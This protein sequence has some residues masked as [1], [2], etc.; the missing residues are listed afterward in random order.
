MRVVLGRLVE[1]V[2]TICQVVLGGRSLGGKR[3][4]DTLGM[5]HLQRTIY[6]VGRDMVE[7]L[8]LVA[9]RQRFPVE[10][11]GLEHRE[12]THDVGLG[13]G[14]R[15]LNRA[16][17]VAL[18]SQVDDAGD[19]L[20][21]HQLVDRLEVADISPHEAIVRTVLDVLEVSQVARIGQL[22]HVDDAVVRI[23]VYKQAHNMAPDKSGSA[24][25]DD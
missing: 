8:T 9:F 3:R 16:I 7:A 13:E 14:E 11:G 25:D 20:F 24:G 2:T 5:G 19:L 6:L 22:I 17:Y 21:L 23:L 1:E 18:S 10:L 15:I 4:F 12:R